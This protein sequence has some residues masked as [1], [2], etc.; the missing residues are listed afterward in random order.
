MTDW[1]LNLVNLSVEIFFKKAKTTVIK[2]YSILYT[3]LDGMF[4]LM[5]KN[6]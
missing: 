2:I 3:E 1:L 6:P 5:Q 4:Q